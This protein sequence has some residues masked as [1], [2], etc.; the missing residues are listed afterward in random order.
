MGGWCPSNFSIISSIFRKTREILFFRKHNFSGTTNGLNF[1]LCMLI[2]CGG[3][4]IDAIAHV[5][6]SFPNFSQKCEKIDHFT[7][8]CLGSTK[9]VE[10]K[11]NVELGRL[12]HI[13]FLFIFC[14]FQKKICTI[15]SFSVEVLTWRAFTCATS[16][17]KDP[18]V[19]DEYS[20]HSL[21]KML[22]KIHF[23]IHFT[24]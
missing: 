10:A 17:A 6:F 22:S 24:T 4:E 13:Y 2:A 1:K 8:E 7:R 23:F 3:W 15:P 20:P 18:A 11:S 19:H 21:V 12:M 9:G 16:C 5:L 14:I